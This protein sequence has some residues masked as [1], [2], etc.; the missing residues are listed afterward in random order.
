MAIILALHGVIATHN[1][2]WLLRRCCFL[3][4]NAGVAAAFVV[5][6]AAAVGNTGSLWCCPSEYAVLIVHGNCI[7]ASIYRVAPCADDAVAL[8]CAT[9]SINADD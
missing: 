9:A 6:R 7:A 1:A 8:G 3:N 2:A 4:P 5:F